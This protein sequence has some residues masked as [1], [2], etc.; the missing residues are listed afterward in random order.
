MEPNLSP[1]IF[2]APLGKQIHWAP[3][4][5]DFPCQQITDQISQILDIPSAWIFLMTDEGVI[6]SPSSLVSKHKTKSLYVFDKEDAKNRIAD[7]D[8]W[9]NNLI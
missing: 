2:F 1:K 4:S 7:V 8:K 6:I 3:K 9:L 5:F